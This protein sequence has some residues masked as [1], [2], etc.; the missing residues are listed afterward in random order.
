M[1]AGRF[2]GLHDIRVEDVPDPTIE[3]PTDAI[4]KITYT[5]I[6]GS[7]LWWYRGIL[8]RDVGAPIGHE[9]MGEVISVGDS[10]SKVAVGDLVVGP[11]FWC[12]G[13]C[14]ECKKG[15]SSHC[16]NGGSWGTKGTAGCQAEQLRVPFADANLFVIPKNADEQLMPSLLAL[17]DVM[18]TGYYAALSGGVTQGVTVAVV[19][20]GAVGLCAVLASKRLGAEKIILMSRHED[21]QKVGSQFGATDIVSQR[22]GDGIEKVKALTQTIGADCILDCVGAAPAREMA[23]GMVRPGGRIGCVGIPENVPDIKAGD[24][25]W[26]NITIG[27]GI[28]PTRTYIPELMPDVLSGKLNPSPVFDLIL[29]LSELAKG[30][31]AMDKREAIKVLIKPKN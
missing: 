4:L 25:F 26:K 5:C 17:S 13:T 27:G 3:K 22:G 19:G 20:D 30:Y 24:I 8:K 10:V 14:P 21:R 12:D 28:A 1:K 7:D 15:M 9:F 23:M 18:G 29:P 11:F 6:C 16:L 31:E 2:Y